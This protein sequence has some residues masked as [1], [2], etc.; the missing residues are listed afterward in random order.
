MLKQPLFFYVSTYNIVFTN[1]Y[2]GKSSQLHN[3]TM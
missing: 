3:K 2:I 1:C